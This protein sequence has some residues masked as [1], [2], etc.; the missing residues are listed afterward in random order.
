MR[1]TRS[2]RGKKNAPPVLLV[3]G[4]DSSVL[5]FRFVLPQL[6]EAGY[7]VHAM[8]WWTGGFTDREP[9]LNNVAQSSS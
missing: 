5:E 8:D 6:V 4:F 7:E 3:H 9:F 2:A 1:R